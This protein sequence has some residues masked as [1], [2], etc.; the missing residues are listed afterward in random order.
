MPQK[1]KPNS[2][3]FSEILFF[4]FNT[5]GLQNQKI[6]FQEMFEF[7]VLFLEKIKQKSQTFSDLFLF[8][9]HR[10]LKTKN[11]ILENV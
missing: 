3:T 9:I 1:I 11:K 2:Q 6:K 4:D 8:L 10:A 7:V 5:Q